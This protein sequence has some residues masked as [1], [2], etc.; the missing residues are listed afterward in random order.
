[1]LIVQKTHVVSKGLM[2][3]E[4]YDGCFKCHC[5]NNLPS[6]GMDQNLVDVLNEAGIRPDEI[7]CGYRCPSHNAAVGGVPNSQ[8]VDGTAADVDA[9]RWGVEALATKFESLRADGVGRYPGEAGNFV[10]VDTR[11]GR[12][13][14]GYRWDG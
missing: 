6:Q 7:N 10:H 4:K 11:D 9:S 5:C 13:D 14:G 2:K 12:V 3:V 1:M 8:H